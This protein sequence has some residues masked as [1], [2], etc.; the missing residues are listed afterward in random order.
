M[1]RLL[2]ETVHWV[3][4]STGSPLRVPSMLGCSRCCGVVAPAFGG[5]R[6]RDGLRGYIW[7]CSIQSSQVTK[8]YRSALTGQCAA[9]QSRQAV[10]ARLPT[11]LAGGS[12]ASTGRPPAAA[13]G[14]NA[15][16]AAAT[17]IDPTSVTDPERRGC[18]GT[19]PRVGE[20][21][22]QLSARQAINQVP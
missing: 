14:E 20:P 17:R 16:R 11:T 1:R 18:M 5:T 21:A 15:T 6:P 7:V 22:S 10:A 12:Q 3:A 4:G 19:P 9:T 8:G 2:A 13:K